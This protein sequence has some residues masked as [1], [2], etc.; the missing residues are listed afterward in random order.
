ML[1]NNNTKM[2]KLKIFFL[3]EDKTQEKLS[4]IWERGT[5]SVVVPLNTNCFV[6]ISGKK[7]IIHIYI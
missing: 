1:Q 4:I 2:I 7:N 5:I 3:Y 6:K